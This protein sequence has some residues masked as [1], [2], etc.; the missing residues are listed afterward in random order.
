MAFSVHKVHERRELLEH[1]DTEAFHA[2]ELHRFKTLNTWRRETADA[3][4]CIFPDLKRRR[5]QIPEILRVARSIAQNF[6]D[7]WKGTLSEMCKVW[8]ESY[9]KASSLGVT[10]E[11]GVECGW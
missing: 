6:W 7:L 4:A 8:K 11:N 3:G 1:F 10:N 2:S 9:M 5:Q